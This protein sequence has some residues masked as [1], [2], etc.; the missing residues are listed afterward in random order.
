VSVAEVLHRPVYMIECSCEDTYLLFSSRRDN[1]TRS[2]EPERILQ[3]EHFYHDRPLLLL[4]I[5]PMQP[6]LEQ[7]LEAEGFEVEPLKTFRDAEEYGESFYFY[8]LT[9]K[10]A[11]TAG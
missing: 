10:K 5:L 8:R 9:L 1:F 4:P 2:D 7:A 6:E 11:A 3:A